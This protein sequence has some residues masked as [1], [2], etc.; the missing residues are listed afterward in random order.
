MLPGWAGAFAD[1]L[2][3]VR[4]FLLLDLRHGE[5]RHDEA[6]RGELRTG[7][8]TGRVFQVD[9]KTLVL[10]HAGHDSGALLRLVAMPAAPHDECFTHRSFSLSLQSMS[11][12]GSRLRQ[13]LPENRCVGI[14]QNGRPFEGGRNRPWLPGRRSFEDAVHDL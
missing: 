6:H 1:S 5:D 2:G 14:V 13:P 9:L 12:G 7:K 10:Q 8:G 11:G 3:Q 4:H